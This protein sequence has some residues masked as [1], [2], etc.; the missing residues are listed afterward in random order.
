ML[1]RIKP[2]MLLLICSVLWSIPV[3]SS[4]GA[5]GQILGGTKEAPVKIEVYSDFQC[6]SCRELYLGTIRQ[7]IQEYSSKNKVCVIYHEFPLRSHQYS[8]QAARF[9]SAAAKLGTKK[10]LAVMDSLFTDQ[11]Y[12]SQDGNLEKTIA[13]ALLPADLIKVKQIMQDSLT[14][15]NSE[16]EEEITAGNLKKVSSTPT[17]FIYYDGKQKRVEGQVIYLTMKEFLDKIVK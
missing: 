5:S 10:L 7:V 1:C 11:A 15:I 9:T 6:P 4:T 17:M 14:S 13:K 2:L 8:R 16:I 3:Q 12:W